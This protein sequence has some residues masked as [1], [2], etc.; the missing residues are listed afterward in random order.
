MNSESEDISEK[1]SISKFNFYKDEL[2]KKNKKQ[3]AP[4]LS[5][6]IK[7]SNQNSISE[8]ISDWEINLPKKKIELLIEEDT[9]EKKNYKKRPINKKKLQKKIFYIKKTKNQEKLI[10]NNLSESNTENSR[11]INSIKIHFPYKPYKVQKEYMKTILK[12]LINKKNAILESPTGTG[13]TLSLLTSS[14]AYLKEKKKTNKKIKILYFSKTHF[15]LKQA[16]KELKKTVY[17]PKMMVLS[18]RDKSCTNPDLNSLEGNIKI[19][20]CQDLVKKKKCDFYNNFKKGFDIG[21]GRDI[22]DL[23]DVVGKGFENKICG[24]HYFKNF[25]DYDLIFLPFFY[26]LDFKFRERNRNLIQ[27]SILIFDEAHNIL[28]S[29]ENG[30]NFS[31]SLN[32]LFFLK[33][34]LEKYVKYLGKYKKNKEKEKIKSLI[35]FFENFE[36]NLKKDCRN[37]ENFILKGQYIFELL[38]RSLENKAKKL[39]I[40]EIEILLK[41]V[42]KLS[43]ASKRRFFLKPHQISNLMKIIDFFNFINILLK[44]LKESRLDNSIINFIT[45][46]RINLKIN[47]E[48]IFINLICLSANFSFN[49]IQELNPLSIIITSGTL[50]PLKNFKT[51]IGIN[52][53]YSLKND[54]V[55]DIKKNVFSCIL[56]HLG[57][58][59]KLD[60][61]FKNRKNLNL[62]LEIG[63]SIYNI[64]KIVPEG[65]LVFFTSYNSL[66]HY[67]KTWKENKIY[68]KIKSLKKI[69][70]ETENSFTSNSILKNYIKFHKKGAIYLAVCKGKLSEGMDFID[71]MARCVIMIGLPLA[72]IKDKK[73]K[74]KME[75]LDDLKKIS[76][77]DRKFLYDSGDWYYSV[78]MRAVNQAFGRVIRHKNDFGAIILYG[79]RY[80]CRFVK[81]NLADWVRDNVVTYSNCDYLKHLKKFFLSFQKETFFKKIEVEKNDNDDR[82]I[83]NEIGK[84]IFDVNFE[85]NKNKKIDF[86]NKARNFE[87]HKER[88]EEEIISSNW[89][90]IFFSSNPSSFKNENKIENFNFY[91]NSENFTFKNDQLLKTEKNNNIFFGKFETYRKQK[92]IKY[93]QE[94]NFQI[95]KQ[96][97]CKKKIKKPNTNKMAQ[98][99]AICYEQKENILSSKC[100]HLACEKCWVDYIKKKNQCF[101]C[102]K[103]IKTKKDLFKIF[104]N[105]DFE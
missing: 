83:N 35:S 72:N 24:Y 41:K 1:S 94:T 58:E 74:A 70:I 25:N 64:S 80:D 55:V 59:T 5:S 29:A 42:K 71:S 56:T 12:T 104:F 103:S 99:C 73:I 82:V 96:F 20:K 98:F 16:I 75:Y 90:D 43:R 18:G 39:Q 10:F 32:Q 93:I 76:F 3:I 87:I 11:K 30:A 13:K 69:F 37:K 26:G 50:S 92:N 61:T 31:I 66:K 23:E 62:I 15:Q 17:R 34:N 4:Y 79:M 45:K 51:E 105:I 14:L 2:E 78:A 101:M 38:K 49:R 21:I 95:L 27:N 53:F 81:E 8:E 97:N 48:T 54:H 57:N 40:S 67:L 65:L 7:K 46:F 19:L 22:F 33:L 88:N 102:R 52:F 77:R 6:K 84:Q 28:E 36:K 91:M 68:K 47:N 9:T 100:G 44:N 86:F 63:E 89:N 60:M 85:I